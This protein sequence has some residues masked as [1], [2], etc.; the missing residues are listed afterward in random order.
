MAGCF[1]Q[2]SLQQLP[3]KRVLS[4]FAVQVNTVGDKTCGGGKNDILLLF[5]RKP[6]IEFKAFFAWVLQ[7]ISQVRRVLKQAL[8]RNF[9]RIF[10]MFVLISCV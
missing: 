1:V 2:A 9:S 7:D 3:V 6:V 5:Y 8:N 4:A 10:H